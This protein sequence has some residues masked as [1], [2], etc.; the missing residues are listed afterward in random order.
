MFKNFI[1]FALDFLI[2]FLIFNNCQKYKTKADSFLFC[3]SLKTLWH[4]GCKK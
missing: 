2:Y 4:S 3:G 1:Y